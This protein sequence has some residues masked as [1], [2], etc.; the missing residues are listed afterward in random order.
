MTSTA[1][2]KNSSSGMARR[3]VKGLNKVTSKGHVYWYAWRGRDAPRVMGEYGTPE[4]WASYDAAIRDR[5]IP[6]PGKFRSL[7]ALYRGSSDYEKLAASTKEHWGPWLDRIATYFGP[8]SIAQF[9]RPEKIRGIIRQW[10]NKFADKPRTADMGMQVLSRVL[11][12]AVDPLGKIAGNPCIGIK[13]LYSNDR[14]AVIWTDSD[15]RSIKPLCTPALAHVIDL[16]AATGLR[17]GDLLRL[18]WSHIQEDAIVIAT[19]KSRHRREAIIP[20]YNGLRDVLAR[21]PKCTDCLD[22]RQGATLE[23]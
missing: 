22:Q 11:S 13:S 4:F 10:R 18:A 2:C 5:H 8:L 20:L 9:E 14:S 12:Y 1:S 16:G 15:I 17:R 21:I 6:E 23:Q 19:G 7:V 3:D